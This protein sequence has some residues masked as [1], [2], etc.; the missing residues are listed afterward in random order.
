MKSNLW[1]NVDSDGSKSEQISHPEKS[2][3]SIL[4]GSNQKKTILINFDI[5]YFRYYRHIDSD[6]LYLRQPILID[7][8]Q[9]T[10]DWASRH[11]AGEGPVN[12]RYV[13]RSPLT[14]TPITVLRSS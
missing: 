5:V 8:N 9:R 3:I 10:S 12:P 13:I 11:T 2:I 6:R 7:P 4:I 1:I 14:M